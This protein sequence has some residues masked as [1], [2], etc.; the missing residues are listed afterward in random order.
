MSENSI[1]MNKFA[2]GATTLGGLGV[3]AAFFQAG[4]QRF[5]ANWVMWFIFLMT[6]GLGALF[7]VALEHLVN[8]RWSVPIRRIP[9]RIA[10]LLLPAIPV[11]LIAL[12]AVPVLYPGARPEAL[13][14]KILAG[15]GALDR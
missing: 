11:G 4:P 2:V 13:Q 1:S 7:I 5:W 6:V 15:K 3:L 12:G 14:N 8:A 9:E 10:T